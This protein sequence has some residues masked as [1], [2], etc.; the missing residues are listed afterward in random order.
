M[1]VMIGQKV[2]IGVMSTETA[3]E[4]DPLVRDPEMEMA[5]IQADGLRKA[6]LSGLEQQAVGGQ[7]DP[8]TIARIIQKVGD[9]RTTI[10]DAV[11]AVH[12]EMQKEQ[13]DKQNEQQQP[14]AGGP[15]VSGMSQGM[16]GVPEASPDG[17][18][19]MAMPGSAGA[20]AGPADQQ[21]Q[22]T[23]NAPSPGLDHL[24]QLLGALHNTSQAPA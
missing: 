4:M 18:P 15:D 17:Q 21:G 11:E 1:A 6:L 16:P 24:S 7:L 2:G 10:E 12:K 19:G 5:R 20:P 8:H 13:A 14:P 23:V 3:M 22:A 9:G